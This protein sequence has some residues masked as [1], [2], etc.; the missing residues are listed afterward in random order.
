MERARVYPA[1][2]VTS[3]ALVKQTRAVDEE[4][5]GVQAV[6]DA[7]AK[8]I[9]T[10]L[11]LKS[12]GRFVPEIVRLSP[13]RR[14]IDPVGARAAMVHWTV[15]GATAALFGMMPYTAFRIGECTPQVGAVARVHSRP[16]SVR[17][18]AS[19]THTVLA[20]S[21]DLISLATVGRPVPVS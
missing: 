19:G 4:V 21:M 14:L 20:N 6:E 18:A 2:A 9:V 10:V 7:S 11:L 3:K 16:V 17:V 1:L 15:T 5:C 13:P 12:V 8:V